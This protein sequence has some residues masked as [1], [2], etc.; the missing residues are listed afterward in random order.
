[1]TGFVIA[2]PSYRRQNVLVKCTLAYL[3]DCGVPDDMIHIFVVSEEEDSYKMAVAASGG[4]NYSFHI[5]P[6]G[7]DK[8]RN[9]ITDFF[10]EGTNILSMDD[11]IRYLV[12]MEE[13]RS[14][15]DK[16][17]CRRYP[18]FRLSGADFLSWA[19]T[20][21]AALALSQPPTKLFGVYPIRNGYFM[22]TLPYVTFDLRFC[23]GSIWGCINDHKLRVTIEEKEDY[24]RTLICFDIYGSVMRYNHIA[25]VT[26]YYTTP[27]GMQCASSKNRIEESRKSCEY[28]THKF[29]H[30]CKLG[31]IKK[32]SGI[33]EISLTR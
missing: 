22:K 25:P 19:E 21:F 26:S 8:M 32:N 9:F 3:R 30:L 15:T 20:A 14:V 10:P 12:Y 29:P 11:D 7:L 27:G 16:K 24:E 33:H 28:L 18:L 5:G 31:R 17:S 1:M 4:G 2:I 6:V 13:D 23:V